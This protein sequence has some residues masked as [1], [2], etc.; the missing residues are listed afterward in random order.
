MEE[1]KRNVIKLI[2]EIENEKLFYALEE[3][4]ETNDI[5]YFLELYNEA[6]EG[7]IDYIKKIYKEEIVHDYKLE[8]EQNGD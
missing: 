6:F 3:L 5:V 4:L 1:T 2:N 8:L 7:T